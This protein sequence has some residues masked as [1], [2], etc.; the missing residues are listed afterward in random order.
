MN[1]RNKLEQLNKMTYSVT[2]TEIEHKQ[3]TTVPEKQ[4]SPAPSQSAPD[5]TGYV[6]IQSLAS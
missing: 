4:T 3:T 6:H 2:A 5:P 1:G